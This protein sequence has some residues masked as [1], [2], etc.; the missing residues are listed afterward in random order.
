VLVRSLLFIGVLS[1]TSAL[2]AQAIPTTSRVGD[3]QIGGGYNIVSPDSTPSRFS[4]GGIYA[5]FNFTRHLGIEAEFHFSRD[6]TGTGQYE[7]TYEIGGRYSR[8]YGRFTP[9]AKLLGGRGVYNFT[10]PVQT[11]PTAPIT[12]IEIANLAYNLAALGIGVDYR[13][14]PHLN[15][16]ADGE[17]QRW[18]SYQDSTLSPALLTL[19]A[20]YHF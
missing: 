18:F 19:G 15:A 12:Y 17:Y 13:I 11:S 20:A 2:F 6:T 5:D 9:Y 10:I 16:R 3:L 14:L 7:K 8:A 1:G 4:G